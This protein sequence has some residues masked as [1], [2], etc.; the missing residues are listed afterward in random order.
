MCEEKSRARAK[1]L[2]DFPAE[3]FNIILLCNNN[4]GPLIQKFS[5]F[6]FL[7]HCTTNCECTKQFSRTDKKVF[8]FTSSLFSTSLHKLMILTTIKSHTFGKSERKKCEMRLNQH[9]TAQHREY[10]KNSIFAC[11]LY[12]HER[13]ESF[14]D[15][16]IFP[17][18]SN[19]SVLVKRKIL[20][21]KCFRKWKSL[22]H[23][24]L[25][26]YTFILVCE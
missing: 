11:F 6:S 16:K 19:L 23:P 2:R 17:S 4:Y 21:R 3:I 10:S 5:I 12:K 8:L 26:S 25:C 18:T 15:A 20:V 22:K 1:F 24:A 14:G 7:F 9:V 13:D